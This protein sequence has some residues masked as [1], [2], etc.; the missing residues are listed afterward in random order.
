M[1][2]RDNTVK[3]TRRGKKWPEEIR[4]AA[5][6][7][8]LICNNL[9]DVARRKKPDE[10]KSLFEKAREN[11]LRALARRASAA[12]NNSI[13]YMRRRLEANDS[14]AEIAAWCRQR[15]DELEGLLVYR[16]PEDP[17]CAEVGAVREIEPEQPGEREKLQ[18]LLER[19][20]PMSDFGAANFART[21]VSVT[22][23]AARMA[24][25][26][27]TDGDGLRIEIEGASEAML[28]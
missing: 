22:D 16:G 19:H 26:E 28:G 24:P 2:Y 4:V 12:A 20:K 10:Q 7:D 15:L 23:K 3:G 6:C 21:L 18:R 1:K 25:Q 17:D 11:E 8:L 13:E 27:E 14:D 9:S 5:M